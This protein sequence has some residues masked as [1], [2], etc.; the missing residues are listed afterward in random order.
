MHI[1]PHGIDP[2]LFAPLRPEARTAWRRTLG[3]PTAAFVFLN[4]GAMTWNK[5]IGPLLAAFAVHRARHPASLLLLKGADALYGS[6]I[7]RSVQEAAALRPE[8]SD[9]ALRAAIRYVPDNLSR[10]ELA[11]L[12]QA[13]D[14]YVSPYRAEG[15]NLPVLEAMAAALPVLVT[16]GGAT[17]DFCDA[18]I[19]YRIEADRREDARGRYLEPRLESLIE[20]LERVT[21][22]EAERQRRSH[23]ARRIALQQYSWAQVTQMLVDRLLERQ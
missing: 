20:C 10:S 12:Y 15:F 17:D 3:I 13:A 8:V 6:L 16:G 18:Q 1:V 19:C 23:S 11:R 9:P 14:A 2:E 5:G 7:E 4:V 21:K 22:E